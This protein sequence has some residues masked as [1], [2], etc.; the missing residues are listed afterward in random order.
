ML[1]KY[2][3][4]DMFTVKQYGENYALVQRFGRSILKR[5]PDLEEN[6]ALK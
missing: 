4:Y 6:R 3:K 5:N 2:K 1:I